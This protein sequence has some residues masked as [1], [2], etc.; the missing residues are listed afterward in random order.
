MARSG[1][2][3]EGK[4]EW[5]MN[6]NHFESHCSC[7]CHGRKRKMVVGDIYLCHTPIMARGDDLRKIWMWY[8]SQAA[9]EVKP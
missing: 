4:H 2:C 8:A 6:R 5:C 1:L 7:D 9:G 3:I